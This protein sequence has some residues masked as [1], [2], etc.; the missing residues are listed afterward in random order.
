MKKEEGKEEEEG[1]N[2][3]E[4]NGILGIVLEIVEGGGWRGSYS[5]LEEVV[6]R[7]EEEGEKEWRERRKKKK[8]GG[9]GG[10]GGGMEW[11]EM[12]RLAREVGWGIEEQKKKEEGRGGDGK[13]I[14]LRGM[15]KELEE[16][17][18][19]ADKSEKREQDEKRKREQSEKERE[20]EKRKKEEVEQ[21]NR[22]LEDRL[23]KMRL[24]IEEMQRKALQQPPPTARASA[25]RLSQVTLL[26]GIMVTFPFPEGIKKEKNAIIHHG[27][28]SWR[29]CFIGGII[30]SVCNIFS[31]SI[32]PSFSLSL[33]SD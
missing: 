24:E 3:R 17:K 30:T 9:G 28:N 32:I 29:Y 2:V 22:E 26:D 12:G 21:K 6:G 11:R 13:M 14:S 18:K 33:V 15:K 16:E 4:K 8:R 27:S 23:E 25:V 19:R 5:E 7:L 10:G 31:S 20:E 1:V